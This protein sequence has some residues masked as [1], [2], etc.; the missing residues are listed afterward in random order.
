MKQKDIAILIAVAVFS[1]IFSL[2]LSNMFFGNKSTKSQQVESIDAITADFKLPDKK[3]FNNDS[4]D[5]VV[6]IQVGPSD[7][8]NSFNAGQ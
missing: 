8:P 3:Y 1:G 6:L 4:I 5:P 7:S 2:V